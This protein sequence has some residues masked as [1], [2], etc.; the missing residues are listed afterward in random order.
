VDLR[1][2]SEVSATRHPEPRREPVGCSEEQLGALVDFLMASA[3]LL[4]I[5]IVE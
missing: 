4:V 3:C 1:F 2:S 5:W